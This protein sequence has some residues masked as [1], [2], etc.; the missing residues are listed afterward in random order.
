MGLAAPCGPALE[1]ERAIELDP[2]YAP[3]YHW[4]ALCLSAIGRLDLAVAAM[5]KAQALDPLSTRINAD[6]GMALFAARAYDEA[7]AQE[8]RT[9]EINPAGL[10]CEP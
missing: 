8:R 4:Y 7:I 10:G 1:F 2:G 6:L 9:L 5:K 3:A